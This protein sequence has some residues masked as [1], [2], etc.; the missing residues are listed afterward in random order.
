MTAL[1]VRQNEDV[2]TKVKGEILVTSDV[3]SKV[4]ARR[5]DVSSRVKGGIFNAT[6]SRGSKVW[7]RQKTSL[8]F[9]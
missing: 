1:Q 2:P 9:S 7:G 8:N 4:W 6:E 3:P 5:I